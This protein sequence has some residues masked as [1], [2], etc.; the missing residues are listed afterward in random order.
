[1]LEIE[2]TKDLRNVQDEVEFY[3]S[4]N[5]DPIFVIYL[6]NLQNGA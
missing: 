2:L 1:V 4:P 5:Y 3:K 6:M